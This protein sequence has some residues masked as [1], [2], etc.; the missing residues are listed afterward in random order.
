MAKRTNKRVRNSGSASQRLRIPSR[1]ILAAEVSRLLL[2]RYTPP[3]VVVD[4]D[5]RIVQ[6]R[7]RTGRYLELA[8]EPGLNL[9]KIARAGLL[10]GLRSA[11]HEARKSARPA[12]RVGLTVRVGRSEREVDVQVLPMGG[13]GA[14]HF[15]VLFEAPPRAAAQERALRESE[16]R[17]R[18]IV[19][20][21]GEGICMVDV[22]HRLTF[23]NRRFA[24]MVRETQDHLLGRSIF[25]FLVIDRPSGSQ[26]EQ[27]AELARVGEVRLRAR[28]GG[29]FWAAVSTTTM[30][31]PSSNAAGFLLMFTDVTERKQLEVVRAQLVLRLV[32][33]QE[34][35]RRRVARELHD[36]VGQYLTGLSLG[37]N[38]LEQLH[39]HQPDAEELIRRLRQ[40]ADDMSRDAHHLA[41]ELRPAALDDL[42][43][44]AAVSN[45][46][47]GVALRSRLEVDVHC[48]LTVRLDPV[49]ETTV[50]RVLQEAL[51]NVV[52][53]ARAKHVSIILERRES[54]VRAIVE[55]DGVG[56]D[57]DR[58]L[59]HAPG[60]ARLG[61]V[62][63]RERASVVGGEL[64]IESRPG[65]GTTLFLR[66]PIKTQMR[67][68]P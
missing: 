45:Y 13:A 10:D 63:M 47:D 56:F 21:A 8:A 9:L 16:K 26:L 52:K 51:T 11:L 3:G 22:E 44:A 36:Q 53:H 50:Y 29:A 46:A 20:T 60:S 23:V 64:Q 41:M 68:N 4:D 57:V 1:D 59:A 48:D 14:P 19:E 6:P 54:A 65:H 30:N 28:D 33:A 58:G 35:E 62:G 17:Y 15:I 2:R 42:G 38:R 49:I 40:L 27:L 18:H 37:L 39:S 67:V 25:D 34:E 61:L 55:D 32:N 5:F 66:V 12:R 7:G 31:D 24:S 43:L